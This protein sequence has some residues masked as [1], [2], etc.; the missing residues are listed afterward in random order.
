MLA[1]VVLGL[2]THTVV[3]Q[4]AGGTPGLAPTDGRNTSVPEKPP[5]AGAPTSAARMT[6]VARVMRTMDAS[7]SG[8]PEPATRVD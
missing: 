3:Y 6:S 1:A 8:R 2:C 7:L 4:T 5:Q